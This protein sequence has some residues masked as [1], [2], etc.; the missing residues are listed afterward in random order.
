MLECTDMRAVIAVFT[1]LTLILGYG[2]VHAQKRPGDAPA[3]ESI[4]MVSAWTGWAVTA[5]TES[6]TLLRTTDAGVHWTVVAP[7]SSS[8][9]DVPVYQ[10]SVLTALI[11]WAVPTGAIPANTT[12]IFHTIDGGRTWSH[13]T[14]PA[15]SGYSI[16]FINAHDGWLLSDEGP[17]LGS[18]AV[19]IYRSTDA[20]ETWTKVASARLG[21]ES[22][23]LPFGGDKGGVAFLNATT[24]WITGAT[25]GLDSIYLFVTHDSGRAW[26]QQQLPLPPQATPHW[27][28]TT[29]PPTFFTARDGILPVSYSIFNNSRVTGEIMVFYIT[30]DGGATWNCTTPLSVCCSS[31]FAD[32]NHGWVT[33]GHLMYMTT[34][35]GAHWTAIRPG[36][37]LADVRQLDFISPG[38]GWAVRETSPFLVKTVDGG[39]T[40]APVAYTISWR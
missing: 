39:H 40:W 7:H 31:S 10:V 25:N 27:E 2:P 3:L 35:G 38:V 15:R 34:D 16:H 12:Q 22:S 17:A 8:G 33:D 29:M 19:D 36:P 14:I 21:D 28:A 30:H 32:M 1:T 20:G 13:V 11:A 18:Q 5:R 4:H 6:S 37:L 23:G 24:G 26:R 9:Q